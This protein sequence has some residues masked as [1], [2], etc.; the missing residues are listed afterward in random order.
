MRTSFHVAAPVQAES[1][2]SFVARLDSALAA[3]PANV[4]ELNELGN[5]LFLGQSYE[6]A[7]I[8]FERASADGR[9]TGALLNLARYDIQLGHLDEADARA[10]SLLARSRAW[11]KPS[12]TTPTGM[13]W[14]PT[15]APRSVRVRR[16]DR[17]PTI[18]PN[19]TTAAARAS[20]S[21]TSSRRR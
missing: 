8:C 13:W 14:S 16:A 4:V 3:R 20:T 15:W 6:A 10:R 18:H 9:A 21:A 17:I 1:I 11:K 7:R 2:E 12:A 5:R 19:R